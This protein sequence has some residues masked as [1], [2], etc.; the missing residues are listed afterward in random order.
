MPNVFKQLAEEKSVFRNADALSPEF[1]PEQLPGREAQE[2][3]LAIALRPAA[4]G[5]RAANC[6]VYGP[7]GTG[8]TSTCRKVLEQLKEFSGR[9][10]CFYAN[11][12]QNDTEQALLSLMALK[13]G[14]LIPRRGFASDEI[15]NR[16]IQ[17]FRQKKLVPII[18]LDEAD[19][20]FFDGEEKILY[21]LSRAGEE[22]GVHFATILVTNDHGLMARAD[23][24][25]RSSLAP[26][27]IHFPAYSPGE[28]KKIL[29]YRAELSLSPNSFDEEVIA[30][31]AAH[32]AK[33]G[34]DARMALQALWLAAKNAEGR[35]GEKIA[36]EDVKKTVGKIIAST[37]QKKERDGKNLG[38]KAQKMLE[39]IS[40]RA[41][42]IEVGELYEEC[43]KALGAS[44]RTLRNGLRE[45]EFKK[46][47]KITPKKEGH[48]IVEKNKN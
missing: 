16:I 3:E 30:L 14:A 36:L 42:G 43:A 10:F 15:F 7:T 8:K 45:L 20:L 44:E 24:R 5:E 2:T 17:H 46:L 21:R 6:F 47:V 12:W 31:C 18:V 11:C 38:E 27:Q 22:T 26:K 4:K 35:G 9:A 37:E 29:A 13:I 41:Q 32:G 1:L 40:A 25:I 39:I 28:L 23:G 33:G 19:R 34:G 48:K